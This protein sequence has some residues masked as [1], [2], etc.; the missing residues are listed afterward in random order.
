MIYFNAERRNGVA[1][2]PEEERSFSRDLLI[3]G[4]SMGV[5]S[6]LMP[7]SVFDCCSTLLGRTVCFGIKLCVLDRVIKVVKETLEHE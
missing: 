4:L 3:A 2:Y 5:L 1:G 7:G 6:Y